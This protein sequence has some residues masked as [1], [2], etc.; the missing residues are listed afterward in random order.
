M[1][2]LEGPKKKKTTNVRSGHR[3]YADRRKVRIILNKAQKRPTTREKGSRTVLP[4]KTP[5]PGGNHWKPMGK[6]GALTQ[7]L[8]KGKLSGKKTG[9][10]FRTKSLEGVKRPLILEKTTKN[11]GR[12]QWGETV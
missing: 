12:S 11:R 8:R 4:A 1:S 9:Q 2:T 3:G 6:Q 10:Q 7:T 5:N